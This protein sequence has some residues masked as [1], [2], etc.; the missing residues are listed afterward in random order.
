MAHEFRNSFKGEF[1]NTEALGLAIAVGLIAVLGLLL[2]ARARGSIRQPLIFVALHVAIYLGSQALTLDA[3]SARVAHFLALLFL[4]ASIGRSAVLLVVDVI[5][6]RRLVR[7][8]PKIIRDLTQV[9][10]YLSVL[11][12]ALPA[13][14][15]APGSLLTTSALF[16]AVIGLSL[17]DTLGNLFAGLAIQLQRPFDVGDWIQFDADAKNIG[18]VLEVNWR[19]TKV[20]T[21][22]LV[23]VIVPNGAL[24]KAPIRN[25]TKPSTVSRRSVYV[26]APA[27]VAPH[28]VHAAILGA[29]EGS[30]GVAKEPAPSVVTNQFVPD[31][32]VEYWVRFFSDR[33]DVRDRVDGEVRDRI[34]YAF[35][36]F[37]IDMPATRRSVFLQEVTEA[38]RAKEE[39]ARVERRARA[40]A[41][42]DFFAAI[43]ADDQRRLAQAATLR[44]YGTGEVIMRQGEF[45]RELY[46][47]ERGEVAL[48]ATSGVAQIELAR[49]KEGEVFGERG[50]ITGEPRMATVRAVTDCEVVVI[51][52]DAFQDILEKSPSVAESLSEILAER[53]IAYDRLASAAPESVRPVKETQAQILERIRRFFSLR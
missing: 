49:L 36:R 5:F 53:Q 48:T 10:V 14:G 19:A 31:S 29:I 24:A 3:D 25:F 23:E 8:V 17:Q 35:R 44:M 46:V 51:G 18:K 30:F 33:F 13:V 4:L 7:P 21:L 47:V 45:A 43:S 27:D 6:G 9:V 52:Q 20:L 11:L 34:W 12:F 16:T 50:A 15:I 32:G 41:R 28:E 22:D 39:D 38:S 40:L 37:G 2:P 26:Y 42:I 1:G